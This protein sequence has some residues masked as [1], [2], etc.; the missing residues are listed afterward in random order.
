MRAQR[1]F[2]GINRPRNLRFLLLSE[3][4][5]QSDYAFVCLT[6]GVGFLHVARLIHKNNGKVVH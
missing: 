4:G 1:K 3:G 6:K 5:K 2:Q